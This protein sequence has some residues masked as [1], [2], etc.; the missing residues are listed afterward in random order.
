MEKVARFNVGGKQYGVSHS[1]LEMHPNSMLAQIAFKQWQTNPGGE[2]YLNRDGNMFDYVLDYLRNDG[3]VYLQ[4]KYISKAAFLADLVYYGIN[5]DESK[6]VCIYRHAA[7]GV[8]EMFDEIES[9][10][11]SSNVGTMAK[12]CALLF[13]KPG[14]KLQIK[15]HDP[16]I[17]LPGRDGHHNNNDIVV[18]RA[19][20]T[21]VAILSL[22]CTD[23]NVLFPYAQVECNAYLANIGLE[24]INAVRL[25]DKGMIQVTMKLTDM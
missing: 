11:T 18:M 21:W 20:D 1:T 22:F 5:V 2:I 24:I 10:D 12:E 8:A 16:N 25:P 15:I 9:W 4:M 17:N 7:R 3:R 23:G 14:C 6:I 13:R 19:R